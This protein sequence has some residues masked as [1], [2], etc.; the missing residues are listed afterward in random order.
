M[1]DLVEQIDALL[2]LNAKGAVSHPVPGLAVEL[3][4][5]AKAELSL[6]QSH[7]T[8]VVAWEGYWPGA[9]SIDSQTSLTRFKKTADE[10]QAGG[11]EV[12]PLYTHPKEAEV[13]VTEEMVERAADALERQFAAGGPD[14]SWDK[15]ARAAL[16]AA[17]S[18]K[19]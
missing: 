19:G 5:R 13:T 2:A 1:S 10:W 4:E 17:L 6:R 8:G 7:S 18:R 12:T 11:A 15:A 3:L 9:G 14:V 16:V